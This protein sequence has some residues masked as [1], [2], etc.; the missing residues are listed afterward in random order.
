MISGGKMVE[1]LE[2]DLS[3]EAEGHQS[4]TLKLSRAGAMILDGLANFSMPVPT[5]QQNGDGR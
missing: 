2:R 1:T 5:A 3:R 4:S